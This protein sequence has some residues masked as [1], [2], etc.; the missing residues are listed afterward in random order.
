MDCSPPG[1]SVPGISQARIQQWVSIT[2]SRESSWPRDQACISCIGRCSLYHWATKEVQWGQ[3]PGL[4]PITG[5]RQVMICLAAGPGGLLGL[6]Q[7]AGEWGWILA[8]LVCGT[9][10]KGGRK[11]QEAQSCCSLLLEGI[12]SLHGWLLGLGDP[13]TD[14]D[15]L[16]AGA[17]FWHWEAW[18][19]AL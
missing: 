10:S 19:T 2:S 4:L 11:A 6:L 15:R 12:V 18:G 8:P 13:K 9:V 5:W 16:V 14:S 7:P 17:G 3:I 1:S